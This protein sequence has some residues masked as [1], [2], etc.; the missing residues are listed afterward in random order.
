MNL[1]SESIGD[2][3]LPIADLIL[4]ASGVSRFLNVLIKTP[5]T[6]DQIGNRQ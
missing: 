4:D 3:R 5:K 1:W 6:Q 2:L